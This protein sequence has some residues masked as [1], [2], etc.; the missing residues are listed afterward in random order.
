MLRLVASG[1]T[2]REIAR[3]LVLSSRTVEMH[4]GNSLGKLGC[5]S[6]AEGVRRASE[7]RL[8]DSEAPAEKNRSRVAKTQ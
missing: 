4:V 8:F 3:L 6:R 5:R 2:D 1:H 7:L